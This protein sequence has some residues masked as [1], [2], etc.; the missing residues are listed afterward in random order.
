[1]TLLP[2]WAP[3]KTESPPRN[4]RRASGPWLPP[5]ENTM[6]TT[7]TKAQPLVGGRGRPG[8][9]A[10]P[11]RT[12]AAFGAGGAEAG[13]WGQVMGAGPAGPQPGSWEHPRELPR[14]Q[15]SP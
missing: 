14:L 13:R 4:A 5:G 6:G 2:K 15:P 12:Q 7:T 1:M 8:V 10:G 3:W 9:C 11:S